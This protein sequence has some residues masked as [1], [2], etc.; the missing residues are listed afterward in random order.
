MTA[1]E[2]ASSA[3]DDQTD[4]W[5]LEQLALVSQVATQVTKIID[6]DELLRRV[7]G[8][9]YQTFQFYVVTL[10][11]LEGNALRLRAQAGPVG[12]F[13]VQ[14]AFIPAETQEIR[15]GEGIIGWVAAHGQ[16]LIVRDVFREDRFRYAPE[17]PR[18]KA[19]VALPLKIENRLLGILDIQLDYAEDFD[20]A[21][22]LVLRALAGQ[23]SM[24]I[25]DTRLYQVADSLR[26]I[27]GTLLNESNLGHTLD[28]I[29]LELQRNLPAETVVALWLM[30]N[31]TL[32]LA[33]LQ[34]PDSIEFMAQ[35]DPTQDP[36]LAA[37]AALAEPRLRQEDDPADPIAAHFNY[38]LDHA[39]IIA[40]LYVQE[41]LLGLL[42]LVHHSSGKFG[43]ETEQL[44]TAFAHQA[45]IAIENGRLFRLAKEEVAINNALLD[46]AEMTQSFSDLG[47]VL[48]AIVQI[49]PLMAGV[50]RCALWL[51]HTPS[52][53]YV[54]QAAHGF[55]A[56]ALEFFYRCPLSE[57]Q[58]AAMGRISETHAPLI[59][60]EA[61]AE[62]RLPPEMVRGL[63]LETLMVVPLVA[64]G[65]TLGLMLVTFR[66]PS[67]IRREGVR[68]ITGVAHQ[69]AVSIASKRL[70]DQRAERERLTHELRLAHNI[71]AG[72]IPAHL[73]APPGWQLAAH[74]QAAQAVGGDFYDVIE[75]APSHLGL[76]IADASGKGMPAALYM[77][78]T[79]SLIRASAPDQ[80]TPKMVLAQVNRLLVPDTRHGMFVSLFYTILETDTGR[81]TYANAGHNPPL[82]VYGDGRSEP[83]EPHGMV[84]GVQMELEPIQA[85]C[86][87]K[88]GEGL[89]LYTDGLVEATNAAEEM[90]GLKRLQDLLRHHWAAGPQAVIEAVCQAVDQ[91][92]GADRLM[93]DLTML[94]LYRET[95]A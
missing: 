30:R 14:D 37:G 56:T 32:R 46:V 43:P 59:V 51:W 53:T 12:Y 49:P 36:W 6:L 72:L 84:L 90:F 2:Q 63:G 55:S 39:A 66:Q 93:D 27:A 9:I 48:A 57:A 40:P 19:E 33:A 88:V 7:V 80:R 45:A 87:L 24:A 92:S 22:L 54:P 70:Y 83:L 64:H 89:L 34:P 26:R 94:I 18:T 58:V 42:T 25:E 74:W 91:F 82:L 10:S 13:T 8:L 50:S 61:A 20:E 76:V 21:D 38:P 78:L 75:V 28:T 65:E 73:P 79:R 5:R 85:R 69:T 1:V 11:T 31:Q 81:L 41:R 67:A 29:L 68:L 4:W 86:Q 71:Q 77:T 35:F 95:M 44:T 16:E 3:A 15:V 17:W 62:R 52:Q 47:R 23:V 60:T